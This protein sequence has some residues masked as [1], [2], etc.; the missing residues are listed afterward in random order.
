MALSA[1]TIR[2]QLNLLLP[3]LHSCSLETLRKGQNRVGELMEAKY[4]R[5]IY[6]RE[7]A[8]DRFDAAWIMPRDERRQG[9]LLY[10]HGGGYVYGDME[11]AKG[12]ASMLAVRCGVRVFCPA[13]RLAPEHPYPAALEDALT[14]YRYLLDKGYGPEHI[15]LCGESAGGGLCYALCMKLK[16]LGMAQPA[17]IIGISP[18]TDLTASGESYEQNREVDPSISVQVL[19]YCAECY[20]ENRQDPYV[21]SLFGDL[22]VMP[23]SLL[24]V[25]GDEIMKSDATRMHEKL[26]FVDGR[27]SCLC[28]PTDGMAIFSMAC[29]RMRRI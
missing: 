13:Y 7:H 16:E 11:Y 29:R 12:F 19:D 5:D 27:A 3:L 14:A 23:P 9:V 2:T 4:R 26:L 28:V 8:F 24:F 15:L 18:W 10:L 6:C 20:T 1:K 25:G 17:G 22:S 21:S